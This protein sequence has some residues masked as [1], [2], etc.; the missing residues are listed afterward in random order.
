MAGDNVNVWYDPE[1]DHLEIVF[2]Q[3]AGAFEETAL[4]NVMQ[5][6]DAE[7]HLLAVSIFNLSSF[8]GTRVDAEST[9][10]HG[11]W[12][13]FNLDVDDRSGFEF[14][15]ALGYERL[16]E[17][18]ERINPDS[19]SIAFAPADAC[20]QCSVVF[21]HGDHS[22]PNSSS[23]PLRSFTSPCRRRWSRSVVTH[24]HGFR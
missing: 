2:D 18:R 3:K 9:S 10:G 23:G 6:R 22:S 1:G 17:G 24:G 11:V 21:F 5:K 8:A 20:A 7:G 16:E 14:D 12:A 19:T 4:E 13:V 15:V